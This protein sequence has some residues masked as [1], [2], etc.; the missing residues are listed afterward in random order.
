MRWAGQLFVYGA[1]KGI[2]QKALWC[3]FILISRQI[4]SNPCL[5][6]GDFNVVQKYNTC[7]MQEK[8]IVLIGTQ[9][10]SIIHMTI[11]RINSGNLSHTHTHIYIYI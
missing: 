4:A 6:S 3:Y 8:F 9:T 5:L 11:S 1:T 7:I 10:L 2:G